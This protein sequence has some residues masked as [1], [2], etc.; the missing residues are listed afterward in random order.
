MGRDEIVLEGFSPLKG[1]RVLD[2]SRLMPGPYA[3]MV[4]A[5]LGA[6]VIK[7]EPPGGDYMREFPPRLKEAS[8]FFHAVNRGKLSI[9]LNLKDESDKGVFFSLAREA[10]VVLEGFRP[11]V[12]DRLGCGYEMV[13]SVNSEVVW[14]SI[15]GFGQTGPCR[16]LPGHDLTYVALSGVLDQLRGSDGAPVTPAIHIA[17]VASALWALIGILGA[18]S[19]KKGAFIDVSMTEAAMSLLPV[20]LMILSTTGEVTRGGD[21]PF[22]G[23]Y[24]SYG[25]YQTKDGGYVTFTAYE[26]KFWRAF[27]EAIGRDDLAEGYSSGREGLAEELKGIFMGKTKAEWLEI[28][29]RNPDTMISDIPDIRQVLHHPQVVERKVVKEVVHPVDGPLAMLALP[30]VANLCRPLSRS[31]PPSVDEHGDKIREKGWAVFD[32]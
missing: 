25:V 10:Q 19:A 23:W 18:L 5:D 1:V 17:D 24:P 8:P 22:S 11:G 14:C 9:A 32:S 13:R 26:E 2:M 7:V 20:N 16:D 12:L 15:T 27:C 6:K 31:L 4:L 3:S 21:Y 29:S 30:I 28:A